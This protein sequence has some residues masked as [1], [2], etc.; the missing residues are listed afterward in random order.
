VNVKFDLFNDT[1]EG[2]LTNFIFVNTIAP[3]NKWVQYHILSH[4][5]SLYDIKIEG[6]NRLFACTGNVDVTYNGVLRDPP[7]SFL[8]ELKK[9]LNK[10]MSDK[11]FENI[12]DNKLIKIPDVYTVSIQFRSLFPSNFN[13]FLY[14]YSENINHIDRVESMGA[15]EEGAAAN[16]GDFIGKK[17]DALTKRI[18]E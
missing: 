13:N 4:S 10:S 12:V 14:T 3:N 15:Y 5:S 16:V 11:F 6:I 2:A 8:N 17:I 7:M 9:H 1:L 18:Q